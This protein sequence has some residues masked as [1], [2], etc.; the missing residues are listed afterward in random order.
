MLNALLIFGSEY[1]FDQVQ[2]EELK[3]RLTLKIDEAN[4]GQVSEFLARCIGC[5]HGS[6]SFKLAAAQ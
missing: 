4:A 5:H 3:R 1:K 6:S 2:C